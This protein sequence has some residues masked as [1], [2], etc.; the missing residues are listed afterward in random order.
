MAYFWEVTS[1]M[2]LFELIEEELGLVGSPNSSKEPLLVLVKSVGEPVHHGGA[3]LCREGFIPQ[4][5]KTSL[6]R[7][8]GGGGARGYL[9]NLG[10][11]NV[12]KNWPQNGQ[13]S[14]KVFMETDR[15]KK[16]RANDRA[17]SGMN[18]DQQSDAILL[19]SGTAP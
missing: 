5:Q 3:I 11:V 2:L 15:A 1:I 8:G 16:L 7:S 18:H 17:L 13:S 4:G 19:D 10:H 12:F 6:L 9:L 14:L